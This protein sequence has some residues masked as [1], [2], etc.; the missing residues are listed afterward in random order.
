MK[1]SVTLIISLIIALSVSAQKNGYHQ[2]KKAVKG[3]LSPV[4]TNSKQYSE[5]FKAAKIPNG[6]FKTGEWLK[7]EMHYGFV[8][9]AE[10][11]ATL[12]DTIMNG[13][14]VYH[15]YCLAE[16]VGFANVLFGV[17][18][19]Y[20][21][22]FDPET[23]LPVRAIRNIKESS[24]RFYNEVDFYHD[25][26]TVYSKR[27]KK[28]KKVPGGIM[29]LVAAFYYS[30]R[31]TFDKVKSVGDTVSF[32]TYFDDRIFN[33]RVIYRGLDKVETEVGK[34]LCMKFNPIVEKGRVFDTENDVSFWVSKDKNYIPIR[35]EMKLIIG[36]FK[37][38]LVKYKGLLHPLALVK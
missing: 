6:A 34:V 22:Y 36:S 23:N 38:D 13:Q 12:T 2:S 26:D 30:R 17:R 20:E 31:V 8:T 27:S 32:Q 14:R 4:S 33:L 1:R 18:D 25:R 29:D 15:S 35:A 11:S 19:I 24:Y 10:L 3:L 16:T 21:S 9:G 28:Y 37:C 5:K 7:Y